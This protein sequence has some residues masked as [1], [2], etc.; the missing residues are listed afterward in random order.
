MYNCSHPSNLALTVDAV[1][2]QSG[3]WLHS[4]GWLLD[5]EIGSI[6][7]EWNW[8]DGHSDPNTEAK[9]VHFTTGGP[10]FPEW[11]ASRPIDE[12]YAEEWEKNRTRNRNPTYTRDFVMKYTFV[13]SFRKESYDVYAKSMLESV[14][15]KWKP[16]DFKLYVYL[17]GYDGKS[18]ELPQAVLLPTVI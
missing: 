7:Q 10:W 5:D 12:A 2:L 3:S 16:T 6:H 11:K 18:D 4:F 13:T 17:E 15:E 8:L 1:N 14:I 9:N